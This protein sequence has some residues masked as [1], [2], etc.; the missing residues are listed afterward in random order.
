MSRAYDRNRLI[1]LFGDDATMLAEIEREFL[2]TARDAHREIRATQDLGTIA[3]AAH[4]LKGT[5]GMV[6]AGALSQVA[7]AVERAAREGDLPG[8]CS[9][10]AALAR[11]VARVAAQIGVD[12]A[13]G[14]SI[15]VAE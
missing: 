10:E 9:L 3:A 1:E 15:T 8:V 14:R 12:Q 11:E 7:A 2:D 6:G 4:R 5:A 13:R